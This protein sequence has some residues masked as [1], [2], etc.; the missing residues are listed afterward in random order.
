MPSAQPIRLLLVEDD[1]HDIKI[2]KRAL[3]KAKS[4]FDM[5]VVRN[6]RECLDYLEAAQQMPDLIL[7][8]MNMPI[9]DGH[10]TLAELK[11]HDEWKSLPVVVLTTSEADADIARAYTQQASCYIVKP[12]EFSKFENVVQTIDDFWFT[13]VRLPRK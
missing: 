10:E 5:D 11:K 7:L 12:V 9:M 3:A 1:E 2:T 6:G 8:D 13:V 4:H